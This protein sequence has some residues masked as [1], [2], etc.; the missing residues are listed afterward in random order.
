MPVDP[1]FWL[2]LKRRPLDSSL[3]AKGHQELAETLFQKDLDSLRTLTAR[4]TIFSQ[5][6]LLVRAHFHIVSKL[7]CRI[8]RSGAEIQSRGNTIASGYGE[9]IPGLQYQEPVLLS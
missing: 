6:E 7:H 5:N 8:P 1:Q 4:T 9:M 2:H 3:S